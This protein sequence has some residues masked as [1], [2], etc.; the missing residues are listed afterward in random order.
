MKKPSYWVHH[1]GPF[2][3]VWD[4]QADWVDNFDT[5]ADARACIAALELE[6]LARARSRR[7]P[8]GPSTPT[9]GPTGIPA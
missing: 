1:N 7:P 9:L 4:D 6:D 8:S 2:Y 5:E 3:E